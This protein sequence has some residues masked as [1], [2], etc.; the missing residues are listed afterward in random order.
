MLFQS[1]S[2]CG[3]DQK[4]LQT[5]LFEQKQIWSRIQKQNQFLIFQEENFRLGFLLF[6]TPTIFISANKFS[7]YE[8]AKGIDAIISPFQPLGLAANPLPSKNSFVYP[9]ALYLFVVSA[10]LANYF[11]NDLCYSLFFAMSILSQSLYLCIVPNCVA[12]S[13]WMVCDQT[14][15]SVRP[16]RRHLTSRPHYFFYRSSIA[17]TIYA[18]HIPTHMIYV[19]VQGAPQKMLRSDLVLVT[20]SGAW[21]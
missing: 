4:D 1:R 9:L 16:N 8:W 21:S 3:N 17:H 12:T 14:C 7:R 11:S 5:D 6:Y 18:I 15:S 2:F 10:C 19:H 13:F 20:A